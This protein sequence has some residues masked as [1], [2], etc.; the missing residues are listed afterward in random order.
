VS[1]EGM[2]TRTE[3]IEEKETKIGKGLEGTVDQSEGSHELIC[4][5]RII[6][7]MYK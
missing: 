3:V 5:L 4:A 1:S 2:K 6:N 7:I